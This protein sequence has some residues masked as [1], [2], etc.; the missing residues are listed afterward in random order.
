MGRAAPDN[1]PDQLA[2]VGTLRRCKPSIV[3]R[4]RCLQALR[5]SAIPGSTSRPLLGQPG[6]PE[7][8]PPSGIQPP[9]HS[10]PI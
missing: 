3:G 2:K 6:L 8:P 1:A 10:R 4:G 7:G 9:T 5:P